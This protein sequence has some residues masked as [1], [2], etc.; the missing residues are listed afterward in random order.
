MLSV[1]LFVFLPFLLFFVFTVAWC[2]IT[3][4][5]FFVPLVCNVHSH[6]NYA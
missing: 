3:F 5:C 1:V 6:G 2:K 4:S